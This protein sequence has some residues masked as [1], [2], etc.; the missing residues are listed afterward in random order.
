MLDPRARISP[1]SPQEPTPQQFA[2]FVLQSGY[3]AHIAYPHPGYPPGA[4]PSY[5]YDEHGF[6]RVAY[7]QQATP[8]ARRRWPT[9]RRLV[10]ALAVLLVG[11]LTADLMVLGELSARER[12][13]AAADGVAVRQEAESNRYVASVRQ[14]PG[15]TVPSGDGTGA[16]GSAGGAGAGAGASAA[17]NA[18]AYVAPL[19][20]QREPHLFVVANRPLSRAAVKRVRRV[21]GVTATEVV[22]AAEVTIDGKRVHTMGVNPSTFRSYTPKITAT[23][24]GLWR[25]VAGGDVAVSFVLGRDG[26]VKLGSTVD[27]GGRRLRVG[28]WATVGIGSI[29]AVVSRQ[30]A[31]SLGIPEGNALI[32]SAP[33]T[34]SARLRLRLLRVLP[35][36]TQIVTINPV[37]IEPRRPA[38]DGTGDANGNNPAGGGGTGGGGSGN[39]GSGG[40]GSG[41]V[42]PEQRTDWPTDSLM[43]ADQIRTALTAAAGKIGS[44]YVWGAEGPDA[45]D[46]SGLVQWAYAQ[47]GVRMPRV[48]NQ[49][50]AT[51]PQVP[52]SE[53]RPGDLLF[54][55]GDPTNPGYISHVAIYWGDGKMLHAPRTGDVVKIAPI[56]TTN[57]AG[58]V[59]VS[60]EV[61]ARVR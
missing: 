10:P 26:G 6:L 32:V 4:F 56:Y 59:R 8:P 15:G 30:T 33:K 55:R 43:S 34:D 49:Q 28:A 12:P 37:L 58:V 13:P 23:A 48:T 40:G 21:R 44:P 60:P 42:A 7:P 31:R 51:G 36:G 11:V 19:E 18:S 1:D 24:D 20:R 5:V 3:P 2:G 57:L 41:G 14:D 35:K 46:C 52:L 54:W 16:A 9:P 27:A 22:D 25:N 50:W 29:D 39:E 61:A 53:A 38:G 47:A 17:G 45:F